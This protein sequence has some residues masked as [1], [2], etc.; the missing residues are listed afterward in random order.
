MC[1][2]MFPITHW[3]FATTETEN[4]DFKNLFSC[5]YG[6]TYLMFTV[7]EMCFA[8]RENL[9]SYSSPIGVRFIILE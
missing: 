6:C 5:V 3:A 8:W 7:C 1:N 4:E 2:K 9:I